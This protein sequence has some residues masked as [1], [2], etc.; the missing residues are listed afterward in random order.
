MRKFV[1]V[2]CGLVVALPVGF[3]SHNVELAPSS[4]AKTNDPDLRCPDNTCRG[5]LK[6]KLGDG[7]M[8]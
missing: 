3:S 1:C 4:R 7:E 2:K 5:K 6:I 8:V